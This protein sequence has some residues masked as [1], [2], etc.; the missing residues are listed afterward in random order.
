M[1]RLPDYR[2]AGELLSFNV[3]PYEAS[4]IEYRDD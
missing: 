1:V 4:A 2:R 3:P